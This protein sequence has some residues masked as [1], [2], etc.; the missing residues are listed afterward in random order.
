[1]GALKAQD[2]EVIG[3]NKELETNLQ[4]IKSSKFTIKNI[5]SFNKELSVS[6]DQKLL[7]GG[8]NAVLCYNGNCNSSSIIIKLDGNSTSDD[9]ELILRGGLTEFKSSIPLEIKDLNYRKDLILD[10]NIAVSNK[11]QD[12]IFFKNDNFTVNNFY[13]NPAIDQAI[14]HYSLSN[15][16]SQTKIVL[17]N[18]LGSIIKEY[19]LDPRENELQLDTE[20]LKPGVYFYTLLINDEGLAT[21]KL[22]VK[23]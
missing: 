6:L 18:V 1:M 22:I 7:L 14:M 19:K 20:Q 3:L 21:R 8:S 11:I 10:L 4:S 5:S 15:D 16:G 13:P 23:K 9:I 12:E 17:Q 2:F